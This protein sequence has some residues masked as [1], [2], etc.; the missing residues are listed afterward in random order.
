MLIG[1]LIAIHCSISLGR[2][3]CNHVSV[4]CILFPVYVPCSSNCA[5]L[6]KIHTCL[7]REIDA[8]EPYVKYSN[9]SVLN[10]ALTNYF[11]IDA[12][13]VVTGTNLTSYCHMF[14]SHTVT[15]RSLRVSS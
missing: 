15:A 14:H 4:P 3:D 13:A 12:Q 1:T 2:H 9:G 7:F 10:L 11:E 5:L 6:S 8:T